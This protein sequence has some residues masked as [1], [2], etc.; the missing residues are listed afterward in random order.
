M[1][2]LNKTFGVAILVLTA[3]SAKAQ[4]SR[5]LPNDGQTSHTFYGIAAAELLSVSNVRINKDGPIS[6]LNLLESSKVTASRIGYAGVIENIDNKGLA[7]IINLEAGVSIDTGASANSSSLLNRS[8]YLGLRGGFGT[9]TVG[10]HWN[11]ED[12]I[13]GRYFIFG[14][15]SAFQFTEFAAIS[16]TMPNSIKYTSPNLNGVTLRGLNSFGEGTANSASELAINYA[17]GGPL[18]MGATYQTQ[19]AY[20]TGLKTNLSTVG[21]S[22]LVNTGSLGGWR[23]HGGYAQSRPAVVTGTTFAANAYDVG[24][25][26]TVPNQPLSI[27]LDQ[28][29]RD[30]KGTSDD[31]SFIRLGGEYRLFKNTAIMANVVKL[32]N[33]GK[34]SQRFFGVGAEGVN[35]NVFSVGIKQIF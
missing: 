28:V 30:Q 2:K 34:A 24:L 35:Q 4:S 17:P 7:A 1:K 8:S 18:E 21:A 14:G 5:Q 16:Q 19:R 32:K 13:L 33:E 25:E 20:D 15:Y 22:Y 9:L 11:V 26:W 10:R 6:D 23:I 27:T 3:M 31:S 12:D 29:K